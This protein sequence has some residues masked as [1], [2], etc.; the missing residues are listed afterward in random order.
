MSVNKPPPGK[1]RK[2]HLGFIIPFP[3][4]RLIPAHKLDDNKPD[5]IQGGP[6]YSESKVS[7]E[8]NC[9]KIVF[10]DFRSMADLYRDLN[11]RLNQSIY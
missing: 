8:M 6:S 5:S 3:N 7:C 11:T 2:V 10:L 9:T 1:N 4:L